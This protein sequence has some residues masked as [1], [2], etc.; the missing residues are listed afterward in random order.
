MAIKKTEAGWLADVQPGGRGSK[1]YRK[2]FRTQAEAKVWETWVKAET[3]SNAAWAPEKRDTRK[4]LALAELWYD[5]HGKEL[6]A[7]EDTYKR[8]KAVIEAMGNPIASAFTVATFTKYR[9]ARLEEGITLNTVNREHAYLRAMFN[10]LIRLGYWKKDNPLKDLRQFQVQE[11]ELSYLNSEQIPVL[12]EQLRASSNVHVYLVA[13]ICL[14][15]GARWSEGE[16]L[17]LTQ[18]RDG[19]IQFARTKSGKTRAVP[20]TDSLDKAIRAHRK[21]HKRG[22]V[23]FDS[24]TGAFKEAIERA[25]IELPAGQLTHVLRHTFASHFMINGGNILTLQRILG[26]QDLKTTMR[27][28]HLAPSHLEA[29]KTLNPISA[30]TLG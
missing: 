25:K 30:L 14:S 22:N 29:A 20:I 24:C 15:T 23:L 2:T 26:H 3:N 16:G 5:N 4:L 8:I 13:K 10:E 9:A 1:R 19:L 12:L 11:N 6:R 7:A 27:Y 18:V 28:A 21:T 17:T